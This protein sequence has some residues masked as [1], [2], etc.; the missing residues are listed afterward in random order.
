MRSSISKVT[1]SKTQFVG[2]MIVRY[3]DKKGNTKLTKKF[4]TKENKL[5]HMFLSREHVFRLGTT[6]SKLRNSTANQ[7]IH[8]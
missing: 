4:K 1:R 8:I 7:A 2:Y 5:D 3:A 6:L